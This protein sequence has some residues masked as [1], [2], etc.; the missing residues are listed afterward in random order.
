[1]CLIA[2]LTS[3]KKGTCPQRRVGKGEGS[4][5]QQGSQQTGH[6][7]L[8]LIFSFSLP[9][10][11]L[12]SSIRVE[13]TGRLLDQGLG[14]RLATF[15]GLMD[16]SPPQPNT[17]QKTAEETKNEWDIS[18]S[19]I[20]SLAGSPGDLCGPGKVTYTWARMPVL[21]QTC[22]HFVQA[23]YRVIQTEV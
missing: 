12:A 2:V 22:M 5:G 9:L 10:Y 3:L 19:S 20:C 16:G 17:R 13:E 8:Y 14:C 11:H 1:M 15:G 6:V 7:L 21:N 4:I 23:S 18:I